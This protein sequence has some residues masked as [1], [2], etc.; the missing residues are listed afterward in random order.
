MGVKSLSEQ[1]VKQILAELHPRCFYMAKS[2]KA[3]IMNII[4][5]PE[6]KKQFTV[7][8]PFFPPM[9]ANRGYKISPV[10][11]SVYGSVIQRSH[12]MTLRLRQAY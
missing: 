8:H 12:L 6:I 11:P 2:L 10:C 5:R 1:K 3:K 4:E 9:S 7:R